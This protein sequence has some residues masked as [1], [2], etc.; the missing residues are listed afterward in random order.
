MRFSRALSSGITVWR[1]DPDCQAAHDEILTYLRSRATFVQPGV[2]AGVRRHGNL[3]EHIAF[4]LGDERDYNGWERQIRNASEPLSNVSSSGIDIIWLLLSVTNPADDVVVFQETK[5]TGDLS[6]NYAYELSADYRKL[7]SP[8]SELSLAIRLQNFAN[9]LELTRSFSEEML[10]RVIAMAAITPK[11]A[12]K[13]RLVPT[14]VHDRNADP[15]LK[16]QAVLT[17][18][19][20]VGWSPASISP[21]SIALENLSDRLERIAHGQN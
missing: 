20:N 8:G 6:L 5:T 21:W 3:G 12:S 11:A 1:G 16:L 18:I 19:A 7:F 9:Y 14:L 15:T 4:R 2:A 10:H 17:S 13:V